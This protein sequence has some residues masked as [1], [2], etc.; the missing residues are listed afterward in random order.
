MCALAP[1][2]TNNRPLARTNKYN[3]IECLQAKHREILRLRSIGMKETEIARHLGMH[4]QT[5]SLICT[6][7]LGR[8]QIDNLADGRDKAVMSGVDLL[9]VTK[10]I[11]ELAPKAIE[12]LAEIMADN[13]TDSKLLAAVSQDLLDR[14]GFAAVKKTASIHSEVPCDSSFIEELKN[15]A[16]AAGAIVD[17]TEQGT[18]REEIIEAEIASAP[19]KR[20]LFGL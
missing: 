20:A 2:T 12:R 15:R 8:K 3:Q 18:E 5:V 10:R 13:N 16:R 11:N 1:T 9:G 7:A 19:K 4:N 17:T 6:S 14:A